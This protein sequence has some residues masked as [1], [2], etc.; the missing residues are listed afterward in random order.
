MKIIMVLSAVGYHWEEAVVPFTQWHARGW[1]I[2]IATPGG[3]VPVVDPNSVK[4]RPALQLLGYGTAKNRAPGLESNQAFENAIASP[5]SIGSLDPKSFD[6][7][8]LVGGHGCLFDLHSNAPLDVLM[9]TMARDGAIIAAICHATSVLALLRDNDGTPVYKETVMTGFPNLLEYFL[10]AVGWVDKRFL[11]LPIWTGRI[12]DDN[13]RRPLMLRVSE[14][15]NVTQTVVSGQVITGV[16]PKA[17]ANVANAVLKHSG[18]KV[19][20]I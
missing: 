11:P 6:A 17:A 9:I 20:A 3:A 19:Q 18:S 4:V 1:Q 10:L 16:G 14:L 8:Y 7:V 5:V 12:L 13:T 15:L 2:T